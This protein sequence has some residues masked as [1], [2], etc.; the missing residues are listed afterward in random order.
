MFKSLLKPSTVLF[1]GSRE[2][3]G[4]KKAEDKHHEAGYDAY[5]TG[6]CF[7]AMHA[8]LSKMRGE[9]NVRASPTS[10]VLKPFLNKLF[11]A[12]TAH[13]DSPYMNLSGADREYIG[14]LTHYVL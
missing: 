1:S 4:Y 6:L 13:Q 11:L 8:H 5:I 14:V 9:E 3:R 10:P 7:L 12:K 2:G